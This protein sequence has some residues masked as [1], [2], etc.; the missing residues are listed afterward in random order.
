MLPP[1]EVLR[2]ALAKWG[3]T[4]AGAAPVVSD[5]ELDALSA[6]FRD[7]DSLEASVYFMET[8]TVPN[9]KRVGVQDAWILRLSPAGQ[10]RLSQPRP[11]A[12]PL[13]PSAALIA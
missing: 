11:A 2:S 9:A 13:P 4:K 10:E 8:S 7:D 3:R 12:C 1:A 6:H 5:G